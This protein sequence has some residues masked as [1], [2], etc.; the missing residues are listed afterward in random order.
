MG[1]KVKAWVI[2]NREGK[3]HPFYTRSM[4]KDSIDAVCKNLFNAYTWQQLKRQG[5]SCVRVEIREVPKK[6]GK[7]NG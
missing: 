1:K 4:R 5:W 7:R 3:L 6:K 2:K